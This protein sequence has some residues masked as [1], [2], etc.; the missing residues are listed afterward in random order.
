MNKKGYE[1]SLIMIFIV[2][3]ALPVLYLRLTSKSAEMKKS[4]G[5]SQAILLNAPYD[6]EDII[7][8]IEKSVQLE[9]PNILAE[10]ERTV[11]TQACGTN[12]QDSING[13]FNR[14]LDPYIK[15]YNT[16]AYTKIP[17]NN[18]EVYIE[19]NSMHAIAALPIKKGLAKL[20][21]ELA[22]IGT[23][24]FAPSFT[25]SATDTASFQ[26]TIATLD[27]KSQACGIV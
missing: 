5:D 24:W 20:G 7:N 13:A 1:Y 16:R 2:I 23:I 17:E 9:L 10:I 19:G 15:A 4:L 22:T 12:I 26:R 14:H 3:V 21:T 18:Y 27:S 11:P 8:Y 25:V 6:K